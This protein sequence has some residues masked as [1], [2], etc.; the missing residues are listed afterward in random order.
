MF[1]K[2]IALCCSAKISQK[3]CFL[4]KNGLF[5]E[6]NGQNPE[7]KQVFLGLDRGSSKSYHRVTCGYLKYS[8]SL[9]YMSSELPKNNA[10]KVL[11]AIVLA[12]TFYYSFLI[13]IGLVLGYFGCKFFYK[14]FVETGRVDKIFL[15]FGKW[16]IH[17][18]HWM[19]GVLVLVIIWVIDYFYMPKFFAG[20]IL[21]VM[22]HDIYDF[23]DWHKVIV[24]NK[25]EN[26]EV[27]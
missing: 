25:P 18:H 20:V 1:L 23:N 21:G 12:T 11:P 2:S 10:K 5:Y 4:A 9:L 6:Q 8:L 27:K 13:A 24:K 17:F 22:A 15:D 16:K 26:E 7:Q 14:K 3:P 19:M